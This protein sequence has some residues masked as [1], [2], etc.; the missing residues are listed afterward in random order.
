MSSKAHLGVLRKTRIPSSPPN[1]I[2][3]LHAAGP[4][5]TMMMM[6]IFEDVKVGDGVVGEKVDF[7]YEELHSLRCF[8]DA[9]LQLEVLCFCHKQCLI[10][11]FELRT[12]AGSFF[13]ELRTMAGFLFFE[14]SLVLLS[15][16][17]PRT[18]PGSALPTESQRLRRTARCQHWLMRT[19]REGCDVHAF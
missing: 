19:R 6:A 4:G 8:M 15:F 1:V 14:L 7:E 11:R 12:T 2:V 3:Y 5:C 18:G 10:G 17:V 9:P 13:F 16:A